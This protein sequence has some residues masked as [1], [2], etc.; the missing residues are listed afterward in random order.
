MTYNDRL[1]SIYRRDVLDS[2][3]PEGKEKLKLLFQAYS[4]QR[5]GD[6]IEYEEYKGKLYPF[7]RVDVLGVGLSVKNAKISGMNPYNSILSLINDRQT[8]LVGAGEK[9][10]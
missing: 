10:E 2:L 6:K 8:F 3:L 9:F 1:M 5:E 7:P 4:P